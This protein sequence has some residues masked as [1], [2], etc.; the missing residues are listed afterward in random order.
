MSGCTRFEKATRRDDPAAW[1]ELEAHA[2]ACADCGE[3]LRLWNEIGQAAPALKRSWDSPHLWPRIEEA[4]AAESA[5]AAQPE[6]P[7]VARPRFTWLPIAAAA[8]ALLVIA[9]VGVQVFTPSS[10]YHEPYRASTYSEPLMTEQALSD[11]EKSEQLYITSIERLSRLAEPKLREPSTL[12]LVSYREKL[13]LLDSAIS[14]LR[15][16]MDQNRFNTHL[17]SQLAAILQEKQRTLQQV[18]GEV[19]S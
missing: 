9:I 6:P 18:V 15:G 17:R 11:V 10:G 4:I 2:G 5:R 13:Q 19:K 1:R 14:D 12:L 3:R 7:A 16:Q 8:A